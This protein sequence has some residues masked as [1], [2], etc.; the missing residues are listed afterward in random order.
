MMFPPWTTLS[1]T[2][3]E[4]D[5][6]PESRPLDLRE[7]DPLIEK[8]PQVRTVEKVMSMPKS[9]NEKP[10]NQIFVE[11]TTAPQTPV[12]EEVQAQ[13]IKMQRPP[14]CVAPHNMA[15]HQDFFK[16]MLPKAVPE[17]LDNSSLSPLHWLNNGLLELRKQKVSSNELIL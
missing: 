7:F 10:T 5:S 15:K 3:Q 12:K 13:G 2:V 14:R 8:K 4:P 1:Y 17:N 16:R 9:Q 11:V 6:E